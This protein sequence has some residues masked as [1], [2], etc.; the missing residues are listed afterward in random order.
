MI[1]LWRLQ[2]PDVLV[3]DAFGNV[4]N[5]I[6]RAIKLRWKWCAFKNSEPLP[7]HRAHTKNAQVKIDDEKIILVKCCE[8]ILV[9]MGSWR[10]LERRK[11]CFIL[12]YF[13]QLKMKNIF[14][15]SSN[16]LS[17]ILCSASQG[18]KTH[19]EYR[20][21]KDNKTNFQ[22]PRNTRLARS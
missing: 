10:S 13:R 21:S 22:R 8:G 3:V 7:A 15:H 14:F 19:P 11:L 16:T 1:Q 17:T 6:W 4:I 2:T 12:K 18:S 9:G 5:V 20:P